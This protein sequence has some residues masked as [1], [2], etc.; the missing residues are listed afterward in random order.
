MQRAEA[1]AVHY[2]TVPQYSTVRYGI[3]YI[4]YADYTRI[5]TVIATPSVWMLLLE[6][7]K[8]LAGHRGS[9][10]SG[11][12]RAREHAMFAEHVCLIDL[13][14]SRRALT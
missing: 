13:D 11:R 10:L 12:R 9:S 6:V 8:E 14:S 7:E 1:R 4:Q 5:T 2:N 3:E